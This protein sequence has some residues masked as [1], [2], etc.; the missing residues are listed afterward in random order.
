MKIQV[1]LRPLF[2]FLPMVGMPSAHAADTILQACTPEI[3]K[4]RC[5]ALSDSYAY[6][7]LSRHD[8]P[9]VRNKGFS[10]KCFKAYARYEKTT[11]KGE[12][13]ESHQVENPEHSY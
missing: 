9:R 12:K 7:C 11:G 4:F 10:R 6:D 3:R 1:L 8:E 5:E 13:V 2:L